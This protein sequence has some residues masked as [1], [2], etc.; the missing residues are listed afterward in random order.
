MSDERDEL[1]RL[2]DISNAW[3]RRHSEVLWEEEKHFTWWVSIVLG[4]ITLVLFQTGLSAL[5]KAGITTVGSAFGVFLSWVAFYVIRRE[6]EHF[7]EARE[8]WLRT[9]RSLGLHKAE[10][11]VDAQVAVPLTRDVPIQSDFERVRSE[12]NRTLLDLARE[13]LHPTALTIRDWF[14]LVFMASTLLFIAVACYAWVL[15]AHDP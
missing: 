13:A 9:S 4:G 2:L 15:Y 14:Q 8:M 1:L 11:Q 3:V 10:W 6:G 12:A 5:Q 7:R